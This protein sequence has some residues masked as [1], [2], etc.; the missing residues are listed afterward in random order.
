MHCR[1][2]GLG[3]LGGSLCWRKGVRIPVS[4]G[5][6]CWLPN[7]HIRSAQAGVCGQPHAQQGAGNIPVG[8]PELSGHGPASSKP[9]SH[10]PVQTIK[11]ITLLIAQTG[12]EKK[13][14]IFLCY[15]ELPSAFLG[16]FFIWKQ[17]PLKFSLS[18]L[19]HIWNLVPEYLIQD[20]YLHFQVF[21]IF[22]VIWKL[23]FWA[24]ME[25]FIWEH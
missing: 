10:A 7:S 11:L 25:Y 16:I 23:V 15:L 14:F 1:A 22:F 17:H 8:S 2:H 13:N 6:S 5:G 20:R 24:D 21:I 18:L 12:R 19:I 3:S 9:W 4:P